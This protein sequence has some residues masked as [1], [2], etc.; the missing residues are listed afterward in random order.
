MVLGVGMTSTCGVLRSARVPGNMG[1]AISIGKPLPEQSRRNPALI[2][3]GSFA[4]VILF[5]VAAIL[6]AP[7]AQATGHR[8]LAAAI[9]G[10]FSFVCHQIPERSFH[11]AGHKFAV[12][13]RCMGIYSGLAVAALGYPLA[14]S[15]K[16]TDT[17]SLIW[18]FVAAAPLAIDWS[19]GY[20]SIWEN[21]HLSRFSSGALLGAAAVFYILP[22]IIE[23]SSRFS[24]RRLP[25]GPSDSR[26]NY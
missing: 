16:R 11:L 26:A 25:A 17:P 23:L 4:A 22:G 24:A 14:R 13:S 2:V 1:S 12:C 21:N 3:W 6:T 15:L 20:F 7:L 5:I 19:L 9:Y 8:A 10:G 18:L